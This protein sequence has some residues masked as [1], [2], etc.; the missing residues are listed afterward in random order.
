[1]GR[2]DRRLGVGQDERQVFR[3]VA[4]G[5]DPDRSALDRPRAAALGAAF[6]DA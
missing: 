6:T 1:M 2:R 5:F 4:M 3:I